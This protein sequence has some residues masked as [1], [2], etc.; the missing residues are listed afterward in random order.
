MLPSTTGGERRRSSYD[1]AEIQA[2]VGAGR[3]RITMS[4]LAGAAALGF[5]ESDVLACVLAL[6]PRDFYKTMPARKAPELMQDVY[7]PRYLGVPIYVKVQV[8]GDELAVVISF[9]RK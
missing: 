9:K 3:Y 1:L 4:S 7:R 6:E 8:T 2:L 5:D